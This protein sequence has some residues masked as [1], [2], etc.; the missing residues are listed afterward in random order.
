MGSRGRGE[1]L[2][3]QDV[4]CAHCAS[5]VLAPPRAL[6][7]SPCRMRHATSACVHAGGSVACTMRRK[8]ASMREDLSCA[9]QYAWAHAGR[10]VACAMQRAPQRAARLARWRACRMRRATRP[11]GTQEAL[12]RIPCG[13]TCGFVGGLVAYAMRHAHA[14]QQDRS[15]TDACVSTRSRMCITGERSLARWPLGTCT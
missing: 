1:G 15:T 2:V 9:M 13:P 11:A 3:A 5:A 14:A 8:P 7:R 12:S 10:P 4:A 6:L